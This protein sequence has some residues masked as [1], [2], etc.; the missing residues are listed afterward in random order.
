MVGNEKAQHEWQRKE[1]ER[2]G[3][4]GFSATGT[5]IISFPTLFVIR[6]AMGMSVKWNILCILWH[7]LMII[8]GITF[9]QFIATGKYKI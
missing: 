5:H 7:S 3:N 4:R 9:S 8:M 6:I 2:E 1:K